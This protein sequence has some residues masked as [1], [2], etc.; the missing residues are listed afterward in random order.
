MHVAFDWP[1][2]RLSWGRTVI[3]VHGE[4]AD[5]YTSAGLLL[6]KFPEA[7]VRY[8]HPTK[9]RRLLSRLAWRPRLGRLILADLSP[10]ARDLD[11]VLHTLGRITRRALVTW[12]D[13]HAPQWPHPFEL[14]VRDLGVEVVLDRTGKE[15]GASLAANWAEESRPM[16]GRIA[17]LIRRRDAWVE[18]H[19]PEARAWTLVALEHGRSYV[20]RL[21]RGDVEKYESEGKVL[22]ERE[23]KQIERV[24]S[25]VAYPTIRVAWIWGTVDISDVADRAFR[26]R[27]DLVFLFKFEPK[28][29]VSL[30]SRPDR[31]IAA[32]LAQKFGGGGHAHAAG[33]SLGIPWIA[34]SAYR[35]RKTAHPK[36]KRVLDTAESMAA[37]PARPAARAAVPP[38]KPKRP[39]V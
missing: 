15:S 28:G 17:D 11:T 26:A 39:R 2:R 3:L 1:F 25:Q 12:I 10:Q 32:E 16:A 24:L 19:N 23:E 22:L 33:F 27:P 35:W 36:A 20:G 9:L 13:H 6:R 29:R 30:R 37:T 5:G 18:P 38:P 8:T 34:R 14:A 21:A 31:P 7:S 4:C